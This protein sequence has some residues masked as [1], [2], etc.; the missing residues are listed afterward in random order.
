[1]KKQKQTYKDIIKLIGKKFDSSSCYV[2][3]DEQYA[4]II[5][6]YCALRATAW[7]YNNLIAADNP[8]LPIY[9]NGKEYGHDGKRWVECANVPEGVVKMFDCHMGGNLKYTGLTFKD[10]NIEARLFVNGDNNKIVA[11]DEA[12]FRAFEK[13]WLSYWFATDHK[14]IYITKFEDV[15]AILCPIYMRTWPEVLDEKYTY[16]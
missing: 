5:T 9:E 4:Y 7:Y 12:I 16:K 1:M 8:S 11:F 6:S 13:A 15:S 14:N 2:Y 10:D 3:F